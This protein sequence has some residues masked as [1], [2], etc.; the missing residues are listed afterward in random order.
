MIDYGITG[1][2]VGTL[3]LIDVVVHLYLDAKKAKRE[4]RAA[5][6][7]PEE[8]IPSVT[9][10]AIVIP[11]L[12]SFAI[13]LLISTAWV[14]ADE[15]WLLSVLITIL[16]P[17]D[18]IRAIGLI[19]LIVGIVLHLW[20]RAVRGAMAASWIMSETHRLVTRG[21]YSRV[22]H[23]SYLS[24]ILSFIGLFLYIPSVATTVLLIGVPGYYRVAEIEERLLIAHFGAEYEAYMKRAG[25][26]H[27]MI[28]HR[29]NAP[30]DVDSTE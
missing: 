14:F 16:V 19:L 29:Q 12:L 15:N 10:A 21:P 1:I 25:R 4:G 20:A 26:L 6:V 24:Y 18:E 22:R 2:I 3:A 23:P 27:P 5:F 11:T 7:E 13:V 8:N 9:M 30:D 28:I 17:P